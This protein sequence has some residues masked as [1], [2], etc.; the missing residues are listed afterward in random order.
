MLKAL[1]FLPKPVVRYLVQLVA[2]FRNPYVLG[3]RVLVRDEDGCVLLVRHSYLAGWYLPGGGVDGGE[4]MADA[5]VRELREEVGIE[6]GSA[7]R[8]VGIYLNRKGLGRDHI[9]LFEV[10][11][12][13]KGQ[14]FRKPNA[15]IAEARFFSLD[16]LPRDASPATVRRLYELQQGTLGSGGDGYW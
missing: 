10:A 2:L 4:V 5:A 1:S 16:S 15:E 12:W 9:G 14:G 3:V 8:L 6:A 7:P 13:E 11:S